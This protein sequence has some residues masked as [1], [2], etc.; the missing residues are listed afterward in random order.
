MPLALA[1]IGCATAPSTP[2]TMD[3]G[4]FEGNV[5]TNDFFSLSIAV[6]E[7]WVVQDAATMA[8]LVKQGTDM[9][10]SDNEEM[11]RAIEVA[12]VENMQFFGAYQYPLGSAVEFNPSVILMAEN[13]KSAP[14]VVDGGDYL[15]HA[16]RMMEQSSVEF[17][18]VE[19][20]RPVTING[21]ELHALDIAITYLGNEIRQRYYTRVLNGF[22]V[23][24][25]IT[26]TNDEALSEL[27]ASVSTLRFA[28]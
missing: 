4:R 13:L 26:W 2:T 28:R 23:A 3:Y 14:G 8:R 5:F 17:R 20:T 16:K 6:P 25:V 19:D 10:Y 24:V 15:F 21:A 22:A 1:L 18:I 9:L 11:K 12:D 27:D 7:G